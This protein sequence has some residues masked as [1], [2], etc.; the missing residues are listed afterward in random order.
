VRIEQGQTVLQPVPSTTLEDGRVIVCDADSCHA[1]WLIHMHPFFP[2]MTAAAGR[3]ISAHV[4]SCSLST[5]GCSL[6]TFSAQDQESFGLGA[7]QEAVISGAT[8]TAGAQGQM[9]RL[10]CPWQT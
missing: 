8:V 2:L 5:T 9:R 7:G 1:F 10:L 4:T 6:T 3:L